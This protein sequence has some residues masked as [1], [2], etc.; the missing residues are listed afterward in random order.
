MGFDPTSSKFVRALTVTY[1]MSDK[2]R[3]ERISI[4][5]RLGFDVWP[6][7]KK[8]PSC[9]TISEKNILNSVETFLGLGFTRDEFMMMVKHLPPCIGL[10]AETVKKKTEFLVKHMNWPLKVVASHPQV[11]GYNMEKRIIPRC[12]V[13]TALMS[14][15]LLRKGIELPSMSCVFSST[16]QT[17]LNMYVRKHD[18]LVPEL[19]AV[20]KGE[21]VS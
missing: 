7:F 4:Y 21:R 17:F 12:N 5:E 20:F 1:R 6:I 8:W 10:P 11:L 13:I 9:L 14:K 3:E 18:K 16:D 15:G 2:A 19:M